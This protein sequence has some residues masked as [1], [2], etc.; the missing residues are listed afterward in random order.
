MASSPP[1]KTA[2]IALKTPPSSQSAGA[3]PEPTENDGSTDAPLLAAPA[4]PYSP[5]ENERPRKRRRIINRITRP[6]PGSLY[7]I[8]HEYQG[9]SLFIIPICWTDQH[10][11]ALGVQWTHRDA[12]RK[13]VPDF[14]S[15][16]SKYPSRP[17]RIATELS[18]DLTTILSPSDPSPLSCTSMKNVMSTLFPA[19]LSKARTGMDLELRFGDRILRR[20][21]RVPVLW[22]QYD[23]GSRSFDSASTKIASSYGWTPSSSCGAGE[24]QATEGSRSSSQS[25]SAQP[26][27]AFVNRDSLHLMRR[28]LYRVLPGPINGDHRN[29]PVANL[30]KL[31]SKRLIP[32]DVD[33][34]PY[35]VAIMIAIAQW[36]CYPPSSRSASRS[37]SQRSSQGSQAGPETYSQ[38]PE[39]R[40]V[41]V[42]IITQNST[43]AEFVIHSAVVTA[44]FLERFARPS[45]A[46]HA[47]DPL[48][49][50]LDIEVTKVQI[51][52][53]LGLKERLAKALGPEIAGELACSDVSDGNIETWETEQE[54]EFRLGNFKRKRDG[55]YETFSKSL[56]ID[57]DVAEPPTSGS[58]GLGLAVASPPLSPRTP[59]R[60]R[61]QSNNTQ[62]EVC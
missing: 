47:D 22:K 3:G 10:P 55:V 33:H 60:R 53:V 7:D 36:H 32:H 62:L 54:R 6:E 61:T 40:D 30:Q 19:T 58:S 13:P 39:F 38:Q 57:D 15:M 20:A 4:T 43:T 1:Q 31:R 14:N 48:G 41:P 44:T 9:E 11:K 45:K 2:A 16:S 59:K 28:T 35:L 21:V 25:A 52:P 26:T 50:G 42:K 46:P 18:K 24:S 51:W 56:E 17:T 8:M 37:F 34:D 49:G 29:T 23:Y 12:I 27:L 5:P